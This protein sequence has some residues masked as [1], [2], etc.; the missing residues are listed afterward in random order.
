ML[1]KKEKN[2]D[3][4]IE[5]EDLTLSTESC[6]TLDDMYVKYSREIEEEYNKNYEKQTRL[7]QNVSSQVS[8]D[9]LTEEELKEAQVLRVAKYLFSQE[10]GLHRTRCK[11]DQLCRRYPCNIR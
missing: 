3:Q 4:E 9:D 7:M 8:V 1:K 2:K 5:F 6:E 10:R 11:E